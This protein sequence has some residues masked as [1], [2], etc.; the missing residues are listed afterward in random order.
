MW[1]VR[2]RARRRGRSQL[3][4]VNPSVVT[5]PGADGPGIIDAPNT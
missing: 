1:V 3:V 2:Q 5:F 4:D